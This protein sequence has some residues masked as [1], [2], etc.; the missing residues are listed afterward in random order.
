MAV[1]I[2]LWAILVSVVAS[3]VLGF[4][5]YGP[6]FGKKWMELN[7]M[8]MPDPKPGF[9]V[10]VKPII[11]SLIGAFFASF[12]LARL[13]AVGSAYL[14]FSG[15]SNGL[16]TALMVWV[17]FVVPV[18]FN[19]AGWEGKSWKLFFI[20]GGYWLAYLLIAGAVIAAWV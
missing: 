19:F 16:A 20:N 13:I 17:G 5:W 3:V 10:M 8:K 12:V 1:T 2:N 11:I 4:I 6:L 15:I 7:G 9:S 18:L 14:G